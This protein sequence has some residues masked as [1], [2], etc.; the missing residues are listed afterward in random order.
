MKTI[1]SE[2]DRRREELLSLS[3]PRL[4]L[5]GVLEDEA[6]ALQYLETM[7]AISH[8]RRR[9]I[10]ALQIALRLLRGCSSPQ[11][12]LD[13]LTAWTWELSE[14]DRKPTRVELEAVSVVRTMTGEGGV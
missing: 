2:L 12:A 11:G 3:G 8:D 14:V 4:P 13:R 9:L 10:G 6:V 5:H 1:A 7:L